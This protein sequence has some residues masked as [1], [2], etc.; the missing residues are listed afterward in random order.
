MMDTRD[1]VNMFLPLMV[2]SMGTS[3]IRPIYAQKLEW[4]ED[5]E[6]LWSLTSKYIWKDYTYDPEIHKVG[7][8]GDVYELN[9]K[10]VYRNT[11]I[12]QGLG[13][14]KSLDD[15]KKAAKEF[16]NNEIRKAVRT[17]EA[18]YYADTKESVHSS[19]MM[20]QTALDVAFQS[21]ITR[22]K[23]ATE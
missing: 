21:A 1:I 11:T 6:G 9:I 20:F 12:V 14:Y 8:Q 10:T 5:E 13:T 16:I 22:V 19:G 23:E 4:K 18:K 15:A 17:H 7:T 3:A 2:I